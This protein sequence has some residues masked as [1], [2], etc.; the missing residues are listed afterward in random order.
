MKTQ[1]RWLW[2]LAIVIVILWYGVSREA[3]YKEKTLDAWMSRAETNTIFDCRSAVEEIKA[4]GH[5]G[6]DAKKAVPL[7]V[8]FLEA[9]DRK[10]RIDNCGF[11][12]A[13][14]TAGREIQE[15]RNFDQPNPSQ[16]QED[17]RRRAEAT[18]EPAN[19]EPGES[20]MEGVILR[21]RVLAATA[22][23]NIGSSAGEAI[24]ALEVAAKSESEELRNAAQKA[25]SQIRNK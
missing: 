14:R 21:E 9:S 6:S 4:I 17:N 19:T 2:L 13:Y 25:L 3:T 24:P 10:K 20:H 18:L 12:F 5:F 16:I 22:L 1:T 7:L 15:G 23:G 8:R 11:S